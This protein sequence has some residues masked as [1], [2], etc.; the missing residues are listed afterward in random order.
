MRYRFGE[1][2]FGGA[3]FR[4]FYGIIIVIIIVI[5]VVVVVVVVIIIIII[6]I[7]MQKVNT[8][9]LIILRFWE[10]AHLPLP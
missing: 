8:G 4:N 6:I 3:Y 2:I 7:I 1:L 10:T 5:V 9:V